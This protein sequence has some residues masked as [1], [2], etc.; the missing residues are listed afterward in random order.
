MIVFNKYFKIVKQHLGTII[1]F[2]AICILVTIAN[3]SY[4]TQDSYKD[5]SNS[6]AI[7]NKDDSKIVDNYIDYIKKNSKLVEIKED[8]KEF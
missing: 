7:I 1:M 3:T 5:V 8:K 4:S 6:V 2:T